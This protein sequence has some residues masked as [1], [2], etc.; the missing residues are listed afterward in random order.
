SSIA[1]LWWIWFLQSNKVQDLRDLGSK[2]WNEWELPDKTIGKAYGYQL[3]K[4]VRK[5]KLKIDFNE[6]NKA[7][8]YDYKL[9]QV[10][11]L[12]KQLKE[13]PSSRRLVTSLWNIDD[14]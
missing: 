2:V 12:I 3:G 6:N 1:E 9:N 14:L 13:N 7:I 11:Y 4:P 10:D 5:M 8:Q